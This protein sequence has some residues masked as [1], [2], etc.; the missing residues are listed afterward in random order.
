MLP[1]DYCGVFDEL[2]R[3]THP[4]EQLM[5]VNVLYHLKDTNFR[6]GWV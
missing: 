4:K 2:C 5:Y 3:L 1:T 6:L